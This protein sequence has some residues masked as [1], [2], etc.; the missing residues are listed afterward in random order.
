ML[1]F[2]SGLLNGDPLPWLLEPENPPVRYWTLVEILD[3]SLGDPEVREA[4]TAIGRLPLVLE[5]FAAQHPDGHWG[6]DQTRPYAAK[7]T[8]G[9][10]MILHALGVEPDE[11]TAVGCESFLRFGQNESGGFSMVKTQ[12]SGITPCTT[13]HLLPCL[14][15]FGLVDD[16]RVRRAFAFLIEDMSTEDALDCGRYQ[17][18]DCLWGAVAALNGLA[19]LPDDVRNARS[20]QVVKRLADTLLNA[21]YDFGGEHKRWF[22]FGVPRDGAA[23][24]LISALH[25]LASHGYGGDSRFVRLLELVLARQDDQGRWLC[26]SVSRTWPLEKRNRPSKWVTL[27]VVRVLKRAGLVPE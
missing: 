25:V 27:D 8:L 20:E 24:D 15:Y 17:H 9:T 12:R 10:L 23:W 4:K 21:D 14:T 16:P 18:Q 19:T 26:G 22:T 3:R 13:G 6:H 2:F 11:R 5:I 1:A 7:G